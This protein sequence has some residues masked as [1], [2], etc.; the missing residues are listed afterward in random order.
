M[1]RLLCDIEAD[2]LLMPATKV[3]CI[4]LRDVDTHE[5]F[6]YGP[7]QIQE[8]I[9]HIKE[10][11]ELIGHNISLY[12]LPLLQRLYG[13]EWEDFKV[14]DTMIWSRLLEP[15]RLGGHSLESWGQRLGCKKIEFKKFDAYSEDMM[16]YC[17]QDVAVNY[18]VWKSL[19]VEVRKYERALEIEHKF[20]YIIAQQILNGFRLDVDRTHKLLKELENEYNGHYNKLREVLPKKRIETHFNGV[21]DSGRLIDVDENGYRYTTPKNGIIKYAEWKYKEANPN[22]RPQLVQFLEEK[23]N[24]KPK[25]KTK[26]GAPKLDEEVLQTL[27]YPEA[28]L[29]SDMFIAGKKIG[30]INGPGGWLK[31]LYGDRTHGSVITCGAVTGRCRHSK[32]NMAQIPKPKKDP[33]MRQCWIPKEGWTLVSC[34]A[35][36]LEARCLA[37]YAAYFDGGDLVRR[38]LSGQYHEDNQKACGFKER[39]TAKTFL[40]ALVFGSKEWNL[41]RVALTETPGKTL[42]RQAQKEMG[43]E[44]REILLETMP[45]LKKVIEYITLRYNDLGYLNGL[46]GRKLWIRKPDKLLSPLIQSA[47]SVVMKVTKINFWNSMR[48][49]GYVHGVDFGLVGDVHDEGLWECP[50]EIA[51]RSIDIFNESIEQAGVELDT[52]CPMAAKGAY[53]ANWALIH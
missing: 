52:K 16:T 40:Y 10:A 39:E 9:T 17:I 1:A 48:S 47:G 19:E 30:L 50:E 21:R 25:K 20:A 41:G 7:D 38:T 32:P 28:K 23:Y 45:G 14:V 24:W 8:G 4:V 46:D 15:D 3:W 34:D 2:G 22:S 51:E 35:D 29:I 18:Q 36:A 26:A 44:L 42:N 12:D 27:D 43:L 5:I 33:R 6:P 49:A 11:D 13:L 31:H 53:G 37:H